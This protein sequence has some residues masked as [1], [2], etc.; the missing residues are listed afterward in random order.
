MQP[1]IKNRQAAELMTKAGIDVVMDMC[2]KR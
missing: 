2:I 1:G